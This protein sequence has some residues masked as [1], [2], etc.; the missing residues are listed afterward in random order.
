MSPKAFH[1]LFNLKVFCPF[2][3]SDKVFGILDRCPKCEHYVSFLKEME[4]EDEKMMFWIDE[5]RRFH[6]EKV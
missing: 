2:R 6:G 5:M 1:C 4:E 3:K